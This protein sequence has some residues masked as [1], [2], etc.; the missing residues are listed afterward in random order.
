MKMNKMY[1][2]LIGLGLGILV[3][4][5]DVKTSKPWK[6]HNPVSVN[7]SKEETKGVVANRPE[8]RDTEIGLD[9]LGLEIPLATYR[10]VENPMTGKRFSGRLDSDGNIHSSEGLYELQCAHDSSWYELK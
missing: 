3:N 4:S 7:V 5:V 1:A 10:S 6:F 2:G 8:M 9:L